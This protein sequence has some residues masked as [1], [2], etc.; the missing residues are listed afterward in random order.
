[1]RR[2]A[3]EFGRSALIGTLSSVVAALLFNW[4]V[5]WEPLGQ[6]AWLEERPVTGFVLANSVS[7]L[8]TYQLSRVWA[9]RHREATGFLGGAPL[10]FLI[11][12]RSL[13][14]PVA[15]LWV[16]RHVLGLDSAIAD[17][18]A[19]NVVGLFLGFVTR[20]WLFRLLVFRRRT[21]GPSS[22]DPGPRPAR[23]AAE[24]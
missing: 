21:T 4:L 19:A 14:I 2:L 20:F 24:G 17:N 22:G 6:G 3:D 23:A 15:C 5:H 8:L 18:L 1:M 10:F 12:T 9:F 7:M 11:S 16:S 13:V